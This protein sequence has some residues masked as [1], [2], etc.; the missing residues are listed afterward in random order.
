MA[1]YATNIVTPAN[2][3]VTALAT[4]TSSAATL[5]TNMSAGLPGTALN[6]LATST[7]SWRTDITDLRNTMNS[8]L[9]DLASAQ[10]QFVAI[11]NMLGAIG[12]LD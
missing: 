10:R 1:T 6:N 11:A 12:S 7:T 2:A 8:A 5:A 9:Q 4:A 3:I